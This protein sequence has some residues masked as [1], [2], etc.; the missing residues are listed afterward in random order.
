[1]KKI[2]CINKASFKKEEINQIMELYSKKNSIG[3]W[4]DY[5]ITFK[6][7]SSV[8][9]I[10]KSFKLAPTFQIKKNLNKKNYTLTSY[11]GIVRIS[12]SLTNLIS[13]LKKPSL[14]LVK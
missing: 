13:Y 10:H 5:S 3:E 12:N 9:S 1:M 2:N 8:F 14:R 11:K 6:S 7:D 4:K